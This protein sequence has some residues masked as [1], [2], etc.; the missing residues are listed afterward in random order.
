[1]NQFLGGTTPSALGGEIIAALCQ[2]SM[3]THELAPF[4]TLIELEMLSKMA[5]LIGPEFKDGSGVFTTGGSNGNML[6][7]LLAR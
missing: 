7:L 2:T 4:A 3:Y 5:G 6:G 1:M